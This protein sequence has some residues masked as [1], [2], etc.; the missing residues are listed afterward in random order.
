MKTR[1]GLTLTYQKLVGEKRLT[2]FFRGK[3]SFL[4]S[5]SFFCFPCHF[6]HSKAWQG[7]TDNAIPSAE[8]PPSQLPNLART[9]DGLSSFSK[10]IYCEYPQ[11]G[12]LGRIFRFSLSQLRKPRVGK[13]RA[14]E[15]RL[16]S[17]HETT[18]P[19]YAWTGVVTGEGLATPVHGSM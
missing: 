12:V 13:S 8:N 6:W 2:L 10:G 15:V 16:L 5:C 17:F 19:P 1:L 4:F 9:E 11:G 14:E 18:K 7:G 3:D